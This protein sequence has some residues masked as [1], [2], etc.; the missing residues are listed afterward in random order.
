MSLTLHMRHAIRLSISFVVKHYV[1]DTFLF[2]HRYFYQKS[3]SDKL[4]CH[5]TQTNPTFP[6]IINLIY[7]ISFYIILTAVVKVYFFVKKDNFMSTRK[8][9]S[10]FIMFIMSQIFLYVMYTVYFKQEVI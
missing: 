1:E 6:F 2:T 5:F 9:I 3:V 7:S 10:M 4:I 8:I